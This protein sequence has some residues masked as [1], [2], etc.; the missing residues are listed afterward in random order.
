M[1]TL[2]I[3]LRTEFTRTEIRLIEVQLIKGLTRK[4]IQDTYVELC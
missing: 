3:D 4:R 1:A 2:F